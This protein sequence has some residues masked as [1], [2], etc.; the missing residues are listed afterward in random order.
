MQHWKQ[1]TRIDKKNHKKTV[2]QTSDVMLVNEMFNS[3]KLTANHAKVSRDL[4][5]W[6]CED[7]HQLPEFQRSLLT[8]QSTHDKRE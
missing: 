5:W 2:I 6:N 8:M 7:Y 3:A 4:R 1:Q